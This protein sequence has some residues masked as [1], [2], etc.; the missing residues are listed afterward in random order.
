M[1][2]QFGANKER[3]S[4]LLITLVL[5]ATM[6]IA[7]AS[8][9]AFVETQYTSIVRSQAWNSAIPASEA[10]LEEALTHLNKVGAGNRAVNGWEG[11][12]SSAV[13]KSRT[14]ADGSR[15]QVTITSNSQ[16]SITSV[17]YTKVGARSQEVSRSI[18][19]S[20]SRYGGNLK[21]LVA[22]YDIN[23]NGNTF[24]DSFDSRDPNYNTSG[25]YPADDA[26]KQKDNAF[27]GSLLGNI[28]TQNGKVYGMLAT[29]P[30]GTATGNAGTRAWLASNSGIQ[31][32]HYRNDLPPDWTDVEM[33]SASG[34]WAPAYDQSV[35]V[36]NWNYTTNTI[37][38]TTLPNPPPTN[39]TTSVQAVTSWNAPAAG[40]F[41]GSVTTNTVAT[42]ST[43]YP[44]SG[45]YYGNVT[46]RI[47]V[48]GH[49]RNRVSTT[50]Y[51]YM[52]Y[53]YTYNTTT[54]T[55]VTVNATAT[56][57]TDDYDIALG[58]GDYI[59][60]SLSMSGQDKMIVTGD[61]WLY[62][63]GDVS[64]TGQGQIIIVPGASLRI[65]VGGANADLNGNGVMNLTCDATKFKYEGLPTNTSLR[66]TGNASFTGQINAPHA[67]VQLGGGGNNSYDCT[68]SMFAYSI[69]LNGHFSFHYDEALGTNETK[70]EYRVASWKEI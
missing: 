28:A 20:T 1:K 4:A 36:T 29:G 69:S 14:F 33:P 11:A 30:D 37:V 5:S 15:F 21:G 22:R 66:M 57:T 46:E 65:S 44:A 54:Y 26:S 24:V 32:G 60:N 6:G 49:G 8:Y 17:G 43:T 53:Q 19:I 3:G 56:T 42:T 25:R 48:S 62:V 41:T 55:Y 52:R 12:S 31:D 64:I 23:M 61:A 9:L 51:D 70:V 27:V 59:L 18:R 39:Y 58:T 38:V 47:V 34:R 35:T 50:Y 68:G 63:T 7:L 16:P 13:T 10:G 67:A 45:T 2:P 40:S